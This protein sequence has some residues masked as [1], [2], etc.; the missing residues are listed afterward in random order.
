M[1]ISGSFSIK[2]AVEAIETRMPFGKLVV[3]A[4]LTL[5]AVAMMIWICRYLIHD[6]VVPTV[7][8]VSSLSSWFTT[9]GKI[10][11]RIGDLLD[12]AI[13]LIA[14]GIVWGLISLAFRYGRAKL[15]PIL[16]EFEESIGRARDDLEKAF[17]IAGDVDAKLKSLD[18]RVSVLENRQ[19]FGRASDHA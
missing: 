5:A 19:S 13:A 14:G 6:F 2:E 16:K 11:L 3:K 10:Q 18:E 4:L 1:S 17:E 9:G 8:S 15:A 7:A 12:I